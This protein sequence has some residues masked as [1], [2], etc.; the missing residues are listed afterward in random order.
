MSACR[1][2]DGPLIPDVTFFGDSVPRAVV[3]KVYDMVDSADVML[4]AGSSLHVSSDAPL[5]LPFL[6]ESSLT[7]NHITFL[8]NV[9]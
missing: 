2:C 7:S 9:R 1:V 3:D 5:F 8:Y 4:V 6:N